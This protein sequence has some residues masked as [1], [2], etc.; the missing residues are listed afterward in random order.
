MT[1][2]NDT[3]SVPW[4]HQTDIGD[5]SVLFEHETGTNKSDEDV[6]RSRIRSA[7]SDGGTSRCETTPQ[8]SSSIRSDRSTHE[9]GSLCVIGEDLATKPAL[10]NAGAG[11][12]SQQSPPSPW[13][14]RKDIGDDS[15]LVQHELETKGGLSFLQHIRK[16]QGLFQAS[17]SAEE[18]D[19]I[20]RSVLA[21]VGSFYAPRFG[22]D[23]MWIKLDV[24]VVRSK[25]RSILSGESVPKALL[26]SNQEAS[27]NKP[28]LT[29][30]ARPNATP[31]HRSWLDHRSILFGCERVTLA[32]EEFLNLVQ[33]QR[34]TFLWAPEKRFII[35]EQV[36]RSSGQFYVKCSSIGK[37]LWIMA[38]HSS[39]CSNIAKAFFK[40]EAR[41]TVPINDLLM[42][43]VRLEPELWAKARHRSKLYKSSILCGFERS[44]AGG[45]AF[46]AMIER[47]QPEFK[48]AVHSRRCKL[49]DEVISSCGKFYMESSARDSTWIAISR[50]SLCAM[51]VKALAGK[52]QAAKVTNTD[53]KGPPNRPQ[54][55]GEGQ[56]G[57]PT[58]MPLGSAGASIGDCE[59]RGY[60]HDRGTQKRSRRDTVV[61][62]REWKSARRG[63]RSGE[64]T[65]PNAIGDASSAA[66]KTLGS[67]DGSIG[68]C[69]T[70][71]KAAAVTLGNADT[72]ISSCETRG[73]AQVGGTQKPSREDAVACALER[74]SAH[75]DERLGDR[76]GPNAS[77]DAFCT[78]VATM[79]GSAGASIGD[80]E[81][82]GKAHL[83]GAQ[84]HSQEDTDVRVRACQD[85]ATELT[86]PKAIGN[87]F[88]AAAAVTLGSADASIGDCETRSKA[89][90]GGTQKHHREETVVCNRGRKTARRGKRSGDC[91]SPNGIGDAFCVT[92][93]TTM[94]NSAASSG[95][96]GTC[97]GGTRKRSCQA[98]VVCVRGR[99]RA[100]R[101]KRSK[102]CASPNASATAAPV[103]LGARDRETVCIADD[104]E[105]GM[106]WWPCGEPSCQHW[107]KIS[108]YA[109][110]GHEIPLV[111][112]STSMQ[113]AGTPKNM[114]I[115]DQVAWSEA[116]QLR[117]TEMVRSRRAHYKRHHPNVLEKN[118]PA[119]IQ[120]AK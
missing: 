103:H 79:L 6:V 61:G 74:K 9:E 101:G 60:V 92:P 41:V 107:I 47:L 59:T 70:N 91:A 49:V 82:H 4:V 36:I 27:L 1:S 32:G 87:A 120:S 106:Y 110:G 118:W 68:D 40:D 18:R 108:Q 57:E 119:A 83:G 58:L 104:N 25:I 65:N 30:Q 35:I 53:Q 34:S 115:H 43:P 2:S 80:R 26:K 97:D 94:G 52:W 37:D 116:L 114:M 31:V 98:T 90:V 96:R 22:H 88:S 16:T 23:D 73:K 102:V 84:K 67:A 7:V 86:S 5:N 11:T 113:S 38:S 54:L 69:E 109:M 19:E 85:K 45:I 75:R 8:Q 12:S 42:A 14:Q 10:S 71:G 62:V 55:S 56:P 17:T 89:S 51:V 28:V 46:L 111:P 72:S 48:K 44:T 76:T 50:F 15:V 77:G 29:S 66:A 21:S 3:A 93:A 78:A 33:K 95:D 63:K 99:K 24:S 39:I 112:C 117:L 100:R 13:V 81:A 64:S 105:L 20:V